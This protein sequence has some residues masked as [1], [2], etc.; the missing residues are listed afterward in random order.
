MSRGVV[1]PIHDQTVTLRAAEDVAEQ[2]LKTMQSGVDSAW[3][4]EPVF[5]SKL[6][7]SRWEIKERIGSG[8]FGAI[9]KGT[10]SSIWR[11][12]NCIAF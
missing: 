5:A 4:D 3:K 7:Q 8:G 11:Y 12:P 10:T 9:F 6:I 2:T 1:T